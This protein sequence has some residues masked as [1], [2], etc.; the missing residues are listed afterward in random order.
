MDYWTRALQLEHKRDQLRAA[1]L[2]TAIVKVY[3]GLDNVPKFWPLLEYYKNYQGLMDDQQLTL[4][5]ILGTDEVGAKEPAAATATT[6]STKVP[7]AVRKA[8]KKAG[9]RACME[10]K[11]K[12]VEQRRK[13]KEKGKVEKRREM[14]ES[15]DESFQTPSE[16]G[17]TDE[18]EPEEKKP[19]GPAGSR[20][21]AEVSFFLFYFFPLCRY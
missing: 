5:R 2:K 19:K 21:T 18:E 14:E 6:T 17:D 4:E 15:S 1:I 16:I 11:K 7:T 12:P 8:T 20:T 3:K 13:R 9:K 10:K